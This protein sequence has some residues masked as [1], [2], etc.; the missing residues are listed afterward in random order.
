M[1]H[2]RIDLKI[3]EGCGGL[4]LRRGIADGVYCRHC[5]CVLAEFPAPRQKRRTGRRVK[6]SA[7]VPVQGGVQ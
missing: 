2:L 1:N 3:C 7:V 4:W 6:Q 5:A